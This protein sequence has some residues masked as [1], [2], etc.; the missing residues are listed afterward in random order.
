M[1]KEHD[2]VVMKSKK[3][4]PSCE[5]IKGNGFESEGKSGTG[6]KLNKDLIGANKGQVTT[7]GTKAAKKGTGGTLEFGSLKKKAADKSQFT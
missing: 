3:E 4:K 6:A 5:M 7:G 1:S 2:S